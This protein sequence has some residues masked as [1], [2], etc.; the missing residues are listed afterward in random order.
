MH[1]VILDINGHVF[2]I[3]MKKEGMAE[4]QDYVSID[5]LH[6]GLIR[7]TGQYP[8]QQQLDANMQRPRTHRADQTTTDTL[9]VLCCCSDHYSMSMIES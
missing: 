7:P 1:R 9:Q 6:H 5:I 2:L 4:T 8:L 3:I